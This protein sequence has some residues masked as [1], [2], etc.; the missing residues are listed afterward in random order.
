M[1]SMRSKNNYPSV[2][3]KYSLLTRATLI[4]LSHAVQM[5]WNVTLMILL[6]VCQYGAGI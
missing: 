1:V 6:L 3:I 4:L 2:I 5:I